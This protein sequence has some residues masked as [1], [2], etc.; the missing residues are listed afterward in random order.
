VFQL[1]G[2]IKQRRQRIRGAMV[3]AVHDDELIVGGY[4]F[5]MVFI[6]RQRL[7]NLLVRPGRNETILSCNLAAA[8][9]AGHESIQRDHQRRI[10]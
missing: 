4:F 6:M 5:E 7:D 8:R 3:S 10:L 9:D 1:D 2:G